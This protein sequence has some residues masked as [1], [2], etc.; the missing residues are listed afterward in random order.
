VNDGD[1]DQM[2][3]AWIAWAVCLLLVVVA[4]WIVHV[5]R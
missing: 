2:R 4:L 1:K 3:A 5:S